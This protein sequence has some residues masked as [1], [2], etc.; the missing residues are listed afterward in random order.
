MDVCLD[1]DDR[2]Q[3]LR[4]CVGVEIERAGERPVV[5]NANG[6][7]SELFGTAHKRFH[8][9]C[10]IERGIFGVQVQMRVWRGLAISKE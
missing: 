2:Q 9:V 6:G 8:L 5:G 4:F 10:T 3:P 1:S 7:K